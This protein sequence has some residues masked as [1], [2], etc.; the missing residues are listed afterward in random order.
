MNT[1]SSLVLLIFAIT[2]FLF[3]RR[4]VCTIKGLCG[5]CNEIQ[6]ES[7]LPPISFGMNSDSAI[8]GPHFET[9]RD[10]ICLAFQNQDILIEGH[11]FENEHNFSDSEN[12]GLARAKSIS[13]LFSS[14]FD[15][16]KIH[17]N[18]IR[19]EGQANESSNILGTLAGSN[20][21]EKTETEVEIITKN[22]ETV[23]RFP[24]GSD[25]NMT[26]SKLEAFL[27]E[28]ATNN[29]DK[30]ISLTGH[31]DN[32]GSAQRNQVLSQNRAN[33]IKNYLVSKGMP[34]TQITAEGKGD[35]E[36]IAENN[37]EENMALNRRVELKIK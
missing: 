23:I 21:L 7:A 20:E 1:K 33:S 36:P 35:A 4:Y 37:S 26:D 10:S 9:Y 17:L 16:A 32:T 25:Q 34:A 6:L 12:L 28:I 8:L 29:K 14:C 24:K 15:T 3:G 31:T 30:N 27:T 5:K 11:Y 2:C 22:G 19:D 13:N 18:G